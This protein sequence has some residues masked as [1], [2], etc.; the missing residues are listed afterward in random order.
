MAT[1]LEYLEDG[2]TAMFDE[3]AHRDPTGQ[4]RWVAVVAGNVPQLDRLQQ[5]AGQ[6]A[7]TAV[8]IVVDFI[9]VAQ[10]SGAS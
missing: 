4:K 8:P 1:E 7:G 6:R 2:I 5:L 10:C 9:H 3:A